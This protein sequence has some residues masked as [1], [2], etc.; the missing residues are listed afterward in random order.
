M[1]DQQ[2]GRKIVAIFDQ[3]FLS[4]PYEQEAMELTSADI[5]Q[6]WWEEMAESCDSDAGDYADYLQPS[7]LYDSIDRY[8][9]EDITCIS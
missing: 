2:L 9:A 7:G 3:Q 8:D 4:C 1:L 5:L 6:D